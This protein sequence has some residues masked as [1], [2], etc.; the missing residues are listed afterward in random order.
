VRVEA[1]KLRHQRV[2]RR[3]E[4][5]NRER[6]AGFQDAPQLDQPAAIVGEIAESERRGDKIERP[7][8]NGKLQSI[9]FKQFG[10][11]IAFSGFAPRGDQ[12]GMAEVTTQYARRLSARFQRQHQISRAAAH[13]QNLRTRTGKNMRHSRH[14]AR[15]PIPVD[16]HRQQM[17]QQVVAR[18][19]AAKHTAHPGGSLPLGFH[20][21][22]LG[23]RGFRVR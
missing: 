20:A 1:V 22:R 2:R 18:C 16:I 6:A 7:T 11:R 9:C 14:C 15:T 5:Q 19:D 21:G 17:I 3:G 4:F 23:T 10:S 8:G 13:I 12:H